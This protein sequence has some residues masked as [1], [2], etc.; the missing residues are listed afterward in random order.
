MRFLLSFLWL[1]AGITN[2]E[3]ETGAVYLEVFKSKSCGCCV[4]WIE[5]L[6]E[7]GFDAVGTDTESLSSFK[8]QH[9]VKPKYQSCHTA[10][11]LGGYVFEGHVPARYISQFLRN[12]VE[13]VIGLSVPGMPFG[14]PGM[15]VPKR[16]DPYT[17]LLLKNDGSSEVFAAVNSPYEQ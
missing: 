2:A 1:F 13:G 6:H 14:S 11:S 16:F 12:P 5:H 3:P 17:V 8:H 10:I 7:N 4:K 15:E 9:G